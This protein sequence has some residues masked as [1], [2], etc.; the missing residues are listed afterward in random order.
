MERIWP[1]R[2]PQIPPQ[3]GPG[4]GHV[5]SAPHPLLPLPAFFPP[6]GGHSTGGCSGGCSVGGAAQASLLY[7]MIV[8]LKA[9]T[10]ATVLVDLQVRIAL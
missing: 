6:S 10:E 5:L 8:T 9:S 4:L 3:P 7:G 2:P 1:R